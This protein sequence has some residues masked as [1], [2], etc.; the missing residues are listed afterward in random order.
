MCNKLN[1][2]HNIQTLN[3]AFAIQCLIYFEFIFVVI[4][5]SLFGDFFAAKVVKKW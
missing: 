1:Y 5:S 2:C 3:C 4:L